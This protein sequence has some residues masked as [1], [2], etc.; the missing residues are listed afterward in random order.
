LGSVKK[1]I[2][3][4]NKSIFIPSN[5]KKAL[6]YASH[7]EM[8]WDKEPNMYIKDK[9]GKRISQLR[10]G[11]AVL[12]IGTPDFN[13]AYLKDKADDAIKA[14]K[15]A[16]Q[17]GVVEGGGMCLYRISRA[18][19]PKSVGEE[20]L[21]RALKAPLRKIIENSAKDYAEIIKD[22]PEEMGYDA[23][24]DKYVDM[25]KSGIIDPAKVERCAL[26]NAVSNA[27]QF[28]T[29]SASIT[30]HVDDKK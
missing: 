25:F 16:L 21:Q 7:L 9:L 13:R 18:M 15:V 4:A 2:I 5:P 19:K 28:I 10:G 20:I 22:M 17:E 12:K 6:A 24:N 14:S 1:A 27:A 8:F 30:D 3:D 26:E 23:K 11:I 29:M